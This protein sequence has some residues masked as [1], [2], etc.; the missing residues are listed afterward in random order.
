ALGAALS[1]HN[2]VLGHPR[3]FVM[4]HAC[5]GPAFDDE[6]IAATLRRHGAS[7][8]VVDDEGA[9]LRQTARWIADG[10]VV[11]WFQGRMEFGPRALGSRSLLADPRNPKMKDII[12][13]KVKFRESFRPFAPSVLKESA[14]EYFEM[15]AGLDAPFML[16]VPPVRPE[17]RATIP[18][19]THHDGTGR[20]QTLTEAYN[21]LYY[22]L[23]REFG[24]LTGVP[25]VLNT[26]FNV[27]GEPIVCTP[28]DAYRTFVNTGIDVLVM[29]RHVVTEK[30]SAV[31]FEAGLQRSV[32]LEETL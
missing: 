5:Y 25:V 8:R 28:E 15:P 10:K 32:R 16:L 21:G 14:P 7:C 12:N 1:V 26:S 18:A 23:V 22:R 2:T 27:R 24:A 31:D 20:V 6:T 13:A 3:R 29:G 17:K 9:L 30:P 11:G 4:D 19:V